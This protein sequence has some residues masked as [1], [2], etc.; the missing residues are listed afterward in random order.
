LRMNKPS[1]PEGKAG[2]ASFSLPECVS[3]LDL[4]RARRSVR[5]FADRE[6]DEAQ[7]R[8]VLDAANSAPSAGNL[9]AYEIILVRDSA[10]RRMMAA[11]CLGQ[12]FV[13]AAPVV[14]VFCAHPERSGIRYGKRG[15]S[16]YCVQDATLACAYAQLAAVAV[17]LASV[18]VGAFDDEA[19]AATAGAAAGWRPVAVLPLG[20]PAE[21]P[22]PTARRPL[23]GLMHEAQPRS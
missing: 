21:K 4:L 10:V 20:Y 2:D 18:W 14:L 13:A 8:C 3:I 17:G 22:Q 9:Q 15:E 23:N 19:V 12:E 11:A 5:A 7:L 16:L 6:I 1:F